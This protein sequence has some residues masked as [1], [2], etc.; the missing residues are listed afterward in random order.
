MKTE[1]K[2]PPR[3]APVQTPYGLQAVVEA[4]Q[5]LANGNVISDI[6]QLVR[7]HLQN[8]EVWGR[9]TRHTGFLNPSKRI[10]MLDFSFHMAQ[11]NGSL[12]DLRLELLVQEIVGG[13]GE[14]LANAFDD[15]VRIKLKL[16]PTG[17]GELLI[18]W[19]HA[20]TPEWAEWMN[21]AKEKFRKGW[22][23]RVKEGKAVGLTTPL[24]LEP[25]VR[26]MMAMLWDADFLKNISRDLA[27]DLVVIDEEEEAEDHCSSLDMTAQVIHLVTPWLATELKK[28]GQMADTILGLPLWSR[29]NIDAVHLEPVMQ[30]IAYQQFSHSPDTGLAV[31]KE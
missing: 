23:D 30:D 19:S 16:N 18:T 28:R 29:D 5:A 31:T 14:P 10:G 13:D 21:V 8:D 2:G 12:E 11:V 24:G 1:Q 17:W 7:F 15:L 27:L 20:T 9:F 6:T 4:S 22:E 25:A 3:A 26:E